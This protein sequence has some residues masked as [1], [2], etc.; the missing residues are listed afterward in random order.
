VKSGEHSFLFRKP[1][2]SR[3]DLWFIGVLVLLSTAASLP[4]FYAANGQL[5]EA[6]DLSV[7]WSR[8]KEFD[9]GLRSGVWYPRWLGGMNYGYGAATT[10]FYAPLTYYALSAAHALT[11]DWTSALELFVLVGGACSGIAF[12]LYSRTQVGPV[13]GV[14]AGGLYLALPYRLI[15][16]YHRAALAELLAFVWA[17]IVMLFVTF[18]FRKRELWRIVPGAS[19]LALLIVTHPPVTYVF[20]VSLVL[21]AATVSLASRDG[22]PLVAMFLILV[23]AALASAFYWLPA[24]TELKYAKQTV[25]Y[26]FQD[27]RSDIVD[28]LL[29]DRFQQLIAAVIITT[30]LLLLVFA[31]LCRRGGNGAGNPARAHRTAWIVV[32][33]ASVFFMS[34]LSGP[35]VRVMPGIDGIAFLWRWLAVELMA[36]SML[37]GLAAQRIIDGFASAASGRR[38]AA[39]IAGLPLVGVLVFGVISCAVASNLRVPFVEGDGVEN[40]FT[41]RDSPLISELPRGI[42]VAMQSGGPDSSATL[43]EWRP[44]KR[45]IVTFSSQPGTLQVRSF[46]FP[47]W[48]TTVDDEAFAPTIDEHLRIMRFDLTAGRHVVNLTFR[49]TPVRRRGMAI[50]GVTAVVCAMLLIF[51]RLR[52]SVGAPLVPENLC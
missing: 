20:G 22:W 40:E 6:H 13:A 31:M 28:L 9:Q 26:L 38:K 8:M 11:G 44:E 42:A 15:D 4:F 46:F 29:G 50:S 32:G 41:P 2:F 49:D 25:T 5:P 18:A 21:F 47:G 23:V 3:R 35:V 33:L 27:N 51:S 19:A 10:L 52:S 30:T 1:C 43:E 48:E 14:I 16:L 36:V 34:P 45:R 24:V 39:L 17:P 37:G 12:Y 7:H